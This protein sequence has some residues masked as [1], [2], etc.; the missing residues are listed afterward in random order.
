MENPECPWLGLPT[1]QLWKEFLR[2][3]GSGSWDEHCHP[4][5]QVS[6]TF[7]LVQ[8]DATLPDS[9]CFGSE[10]SFRAV[11]QMFL[12][13]PQADTAQAFQQLDKVTSCSAS[14]SQT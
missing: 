10:A 6:S 1:D 8:K 5:Q 13:G 9:S 7:A 12:F 3:G 11:S 2:L 4:E 14:Q